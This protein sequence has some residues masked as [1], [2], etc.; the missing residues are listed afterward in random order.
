[1]PLKCWTV[2]ICRPAPRASGAR[3]RAVPARQIATE[4]SLGLPNR[5]ESSGCA[6]G[7]SMVV[8]HCMTTSAKSAAA[9][10]HALGGAATLLTAAVFRGP[11]ARCAAPARPRGAACRRAAGRGGA[12]EHGAAAGLPR[13][14][15]G[16]G[17][18]GH[19]RGAHPAGTPQRRAGAALHAAAS[20]RRRGRLAARARRGLR[21]VAGVGCRRPPLQPRQDGQAPRGART[22]RALVRF[23][24]LDA[25]GHTVARATAIS[26]ACRQEDM[27]P[28]LRPTFAPGP[29]GHELTVTNAGRAPA[30]PFT[31]RL[32]SGAAPASVAELDGLAPGAT[33]VGCA[34][35]A[36]RA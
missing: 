3:A 28:D 15:G 24:W 21:G 9:W 32:E 14:P 17:A 23:R 31:V 7:V 29:A 26:P 5:H 35:R 18:R 8:N 25:V 10:R 16:D 12:G 20:R 1:M 34:S 2:A 30:G 13:R 11:H 19:V 36:S 6:D 22:Y 4:L 27:R 33:R